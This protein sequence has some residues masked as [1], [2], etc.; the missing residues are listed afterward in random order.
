MI[1]SSFVKKFILALSVI[2][3]VSCD[4]DYNSI[5]SDIIDDD[6]HY[7]MTRLV[8]PVTAYDRAT[9]VVQSNNLTL[10]TLGVYENPVFGKTVAHFVTQVQL[11]TTNPTLYEPIVDSVYLY[12]PYFSALEETDS[13]TGASTY[14]LDSVYPATGGKF[15]LDVYRNG[16]F[17]R[18]SDPG[19]SFVD[20]Q[21]YY[22]DEKNLVESNLV[23]SRLNNF[24]EAQ[25]DQFAVSAAEIERTA[26]PEGQMAAKIV[27]R[28]APGIFLY[29]DKDEFQQIM[30]GAAAQGKLVNNNVFMEYFRGLYFKV[31][32]N[33]NESVMAVPRFDQGTITIKYRDY[34]AC[35]TCEGGEHSEEPEAKTMTLNL[36]GNTVNFFENTPNPAYASAINTFDPVLGDD[37]LYVKGG[38]GSM[39]FIDIDD[40]YFADLKRDP[41]TG[42][43]VLVNEANLVFYVDKE[44]MGT[45][46]EPLR[47]LL[48]D[49]NNKRPVIDYY[50]DATYVTSAPKY[51]KYIH[52]GLIEVDSD[53]RG[54]RYKIRVTDHINNL[55]NK[56][57]TNVRLGLAVTEYI[58][59]SGNAALKTPIALPGF[60]VK[61]LPVSSVMHPFGT[62]LYGS[63]IPVGDPNYDKRLKLEIYYTKPN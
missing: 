48:Y 58:N 13:E 3:L 45:A 61:T 18:N 60:D 55:I 4:T 31:T 22:S 44:A 17:L 20:G 9:N 1:N 28:K 38:E 24:S 23:G 39:A 16:Y 49:I 37:R 59:L 14:T 57:S 52:G 32:Q 51:D 35:S 47:V 46:V 53:K 7:G 34:I 56:D 25:N 27:E 36:D 50:N 41:V 12:V 40:S 30:F 63:N 10:N 15:R 11:A 43:K 8:T 2:F 29:F 26:I 42:Q 21:K 33:G 5:G 19:S 62:I 54:F 6:V